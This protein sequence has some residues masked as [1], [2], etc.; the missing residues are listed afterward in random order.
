VVESSSRGA[1]G[2]WSVRDRPWLLVIGAVCVLVA[3][4][5]GYLIGKGQPS[6]TI[7]TCPVY[8]APTQA[9]ATCDNFAYAIPVDNVLWR[10]ASG[11]WHEGDR[12]ACLPVGPQQIARITFASVD[13]TIDG[14]S[15]RPVVWVSC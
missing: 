15:W 7:R 5:V 13:V 3:G 6:A 9:T 11:A 4:T 10:D 12:P 8:V 2:G 14:R 1:R